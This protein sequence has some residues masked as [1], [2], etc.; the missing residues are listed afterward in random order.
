ME[1]RSKNVFLLQIGKVT[2]IIAFEYF[3]QYFVC[4]PASIFSLVFRFD[5]FRFDLINILWMLHVKGL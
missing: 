4:F 5:C 2:L 3:T 1:N